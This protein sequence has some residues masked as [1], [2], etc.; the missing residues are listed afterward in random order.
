MRRTTRTTILAA[1]TAAAVVALSPGAARAAADL[2]RLELD[3][4]PDFARRELA[5]RAI[6]TFANP[7]LESSFA[8]GLRDSFTTVEVREASSPVA[9]LRESGGITVR[10]ERPE[11]EVVL[12]FDLAGPAGASSDEKRDV[13]SPDD[14][15]LLWS[16]RF[17][18]TV[19]DDWAVYDITLTL[20]PGFEAIAPGRLAEREKVDDAVRW[21]FTSA[22]PIRLPSVFAD[23]RWQ[24][25]EHLVGGWSIQTLFHPESEVLADAVAR[26]SADVLA[27]YTGDSNLT[28][29]SSSVILRWGWVNIRSI[30]SRSCGTAMA[31]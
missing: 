25:R 28:T 12:T 23:R 30:S 15:F 29:A 16:D 13:L 22:A 1:L 7:G 24:R 3:L 14:L 11:R 31:T 9:V 6:L 21:R 19:F 2:V 20:P 4:R 10:L 8:F 27:F 17:Y 5:L 26:T 18:P